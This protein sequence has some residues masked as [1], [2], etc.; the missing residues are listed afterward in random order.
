MTY[1]TF[2]LLGLGNGAVFGALALS[3]AISH[4]ASNVVNF[5]AGAMA[6]FGAVTFQ[7]LSTRDAIFNPFAMNSTL[8]W[9]VTG[10]LVVYLAF[11]FSRRTAG[12]TRGLLMLTAAVVAVAVLMQSPFLISTG[13]NLGMAG[14]LVVTGLISGLFGFAVYGLIFRRLRTALPL[15]R[16]VA[17]IGLMLI[18]PALVS[19]RLQNSPVNAP[20]IFPSDVW[21]VGSLVI[22]VNQIL[23]A[24]AVL[25]VAAALTFVYQK[26]RFGL[27]TT[28]AAETETGAT[29]LGISPHVVGGVNWAIGGAVA[30]IFG[31]LIASLVPVTP[32]DFALYV[33]PA[34]AA[35][36]VGRMSSLWVA[37]LTGLA[38]GMLQSL[39]AY[40]QATYTWLPRQ[41]M[42][43]LVPLVL[44]IVVMLVRSEALPDRAA[45]IRRTLPLAKVP[46]H[47]WQWGVALVGLSLAFAFTLQGGYQVALAMSLIFFLLALSLVVL[48]GFVGQISLAQ[49]MFAGVGA[50]LLARLTVD[51]GIPFPIAPLIAVLAT[52][53]F[54]ALIAT[55]AVRVR[56]VNLAILSLS[57]G[58]FVESLYFSNAEYVG[59]GGSP[60]VEHPVLFGWDLSIGANGEYPRVE[61]A[62]LLTIICIPAALLVVGIRRSSLGHQ[63]LAVRGNERS[64]AAD[65]I[66]ISRIKR[67]AFAISAGLAG[68][69]GTMTAY[70][71]Y[72]G[73]SS[74]SF[75]SLASLTV[76]A[77][78]FIMGITTITGAVMAAIGAVGGLFPVLI[79]NEIDFNQWYPVFVGLILLVTAVQM[80]EGVALHIEE[81]K[82]Q[83]AAFIDRRRQRALSAE[84]RE[85]A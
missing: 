63:M 48:T 29:L 15:A 39:V 46:K 24:A 73:F 54:G 62:I 36:L 6:L 27:Q 12:S 32:T 23:M 42:V 25:V 4:R 72:G 19:A 37:A 17:A 41:G 30:G 59:H 65:G 69:A 64:A 52:A 77:A 68:L 75:T 38:I 66:N 14:A 40:F 3:I 55:P 9:V 58:V 82:A 53:A 20:P 35:A 71:N 21:K 2:L 81:R 51:A 11:R 57:A 16:V 1:L 76:V 85:P 33:V 5:G 43:E 8:G 10:V 13:S 47:V 31:A 80:P 74:S 70:V 49:Y 28:T 78:V 34:L 56:G 50:F 60:S 45:L 22:Q 79:Q 26:T 67:I 18:I 83:L 7:M 44:L 61:F 84:V